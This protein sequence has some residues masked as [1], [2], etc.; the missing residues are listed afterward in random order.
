MENLFVLAYLSVFTLLF[1][2][3]VIRSLGEQNA[4]I[5]V[6]QNP[7]TKIWGGQ[8]NNIGRFRSTI[9]NPGMTILHVIV[10]EVPS[11]IK[12]FEVCESFKLLNKHGQACVV[13]YLVEA[14]GDEPDYET[15]YCSHDVFLK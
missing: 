4:I 14:D 12:L 15:F 5:W 13:R 11:H 3:T 6:K 2:N 10:S 8:A 9:A 1:L 7:P